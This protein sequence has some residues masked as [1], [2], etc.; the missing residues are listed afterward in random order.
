MTNI[1][2]KILLVKKK[3][4]D[5]AKATK[6]QSILLAETK[7]AGTPR[8]FIG[9]IRSKITTGQPAII[10]E[11]KK[12]SP[13]KGILCKDEFNPS[14]IA[15]NY[16]KHDATCLSVLTD[17]HFFMGSANY[18]KQARN[19]CIIP[20]LR[21]DFILDEYQVIESRAMG[22][23]CILL[24]VAAFLINEKDD[25]DKSVVKMQKLEELAHSF[26]MA[27]LVEVH[28][29]SELDLALQLTTP[30]IGIN[31]RNLQT[32]ETNLKT[33]L[34][35]LDRIQTEHI[36]VTESGIKSTNDV[37]LMRNHQVHTF[38]VGEAFMRADDPGAELTR[39][40]HS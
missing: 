25:S 34:Q 36:V 37:A 18:L 14:T 24:I 6:P 3:E 40:F 2:N 22:A 15:D 11:I 23:D 26:N 35:L 1:L 7:A 9:S 5:E 28:N 21:K 13:S 38:L 4:I 27:V 19:A 16:A 10:A 29:A 31:N 20:V 8:D 12:A 39:L 17:Q 32:F 33:T 30:L